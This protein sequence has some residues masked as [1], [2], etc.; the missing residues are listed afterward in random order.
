MNPTEKIVPNERVRAFVD[1]IKA[2]QQEV[3]A[4]H[5]EALL[6][7]VPDPNAIDLHELMERAD[8]EAPGAEMRAIQREAARDSIHRRTNS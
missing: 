8:R 7:Q 6:A 4:S 2:T 1:R 3:V 5:F